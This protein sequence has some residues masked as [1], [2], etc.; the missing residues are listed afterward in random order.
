M[1]LGFMLQCEDCKETLEEF[2]TGY[3]DN[4]LPDDEQETYKALTAFA[5]F[6][7]MKRLKKGQYTKETSTLGERNYTKVQITDP[8]TTSPYN[9]T[10]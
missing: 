8:M 10:C 6:M 3:V 2:W 7:E 1:E 4:V 5:L 9:V